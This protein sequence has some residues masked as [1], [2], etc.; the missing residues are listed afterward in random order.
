MT[1]DSLFVN[2]NIIINKI[3][4]IYISELKMGCIFIFLGLGPWSLLFFLG[5]GAYSV[6]VELIL[7][8]WSLWIDLLQ[9]LGRTV[10]SVD[11][12]FK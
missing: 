2:I 11:R 8:P 1:G 6:A 4:Y 12:E 9:L 10:E 5:R 3:K 7:G